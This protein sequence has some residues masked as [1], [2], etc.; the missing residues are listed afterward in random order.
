V[1]ISNF[2]CTS[3]GEI[4]DANT[5]HQIRK[6]RMLARDMGDFVPLEETV[7]YENT[8]SRLIR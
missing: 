1:Y 3:G 6:Q 7:K 4:P 5:I 2:Y 8:K